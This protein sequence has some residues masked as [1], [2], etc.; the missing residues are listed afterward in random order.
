SAAHAGG[1]A[2]AVSGPGMLGCDV[3]AVA[4]TEH[5]RPLLGEERWRLAELLARETGET[6]ALAC[7]RV[8]TALESMKKAGLP[9]Q[10]PLHLSGVPGDGWV[11]LGA[12]TATAA[13]FHATL[14]GAETGAM[15]GESP[16]HAALV[17]AVLTGTVDAGV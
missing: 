14:R 1:I 12:G 8:W 10:T 4:A 3:E 9:L 17:F 6:Q 2:L 16:A 5:W 11:L 7:T 13:T 15:A